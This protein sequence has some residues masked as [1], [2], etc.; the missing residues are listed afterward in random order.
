MRDQELRPLNGLDV[1]HG[2]TVGPQ[3]QVVVLVSSKHALQ[4]LA[5]I[6]QHFESFT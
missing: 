1:S 6:A 3:N 4:R 5:N 2:D